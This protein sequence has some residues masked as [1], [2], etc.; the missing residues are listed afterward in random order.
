M[1]KFYFLTGKNST[2]CLLI[3]TP[4]FFG[5]NIISKN[6]IGG[7]DHVKS[8]PFQNKVHIETIKKEI[9]LNDTYLDNLLFIGNVT[10]SIKIEGYSGNVIQ[11]V[12]KKT[13]SAI[14]DY[15][16]KIG[17]EET[18][19]GVRTKDNKVYLYM[20]SPY[21]KLDTNNNE[22]NYNKTCRG[23]CPYSYSLNYI[24]KV[25]Y[26][27]NLKVSNINGGSIYISNVKSDLLDI[28]HITGSINLTDVQGVSKVET[29]TGSINASY[30]ANPSKASSFITNTGSITIK[31]QNELNAR[32]RYNIY[33]GKIH[34]D[35]NTRM[36]SKKDSF[37]FENSRP[38][39]VIGSGKINYYFKTITGSV[40][41]NKY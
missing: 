11:V 32:L 4:L 22:F 9:A 12:V 18:N 21:S 13:V 20:A 3:I 10:G 1:K 5:F 2:L 33:D 7:N 35:F 41:I 31:L 37:I 8:L 29:I 36:A 39:L 17:I 34:S 24:V 40:I 28:K 26:N 15:Q 27:T 6:H 14:N 16:L 19:V 25:P 23:K 30:V 38:S